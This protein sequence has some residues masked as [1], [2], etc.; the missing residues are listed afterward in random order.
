MSFAQSTPAQPLIP[1]LQPVTNL[2][3]PLGEPLVRV[4]TG[5]LLVPH[6]A[7]KLFGWFG[8]YGVEATGPFFATTLGLPASLALLAGLIEFFGG[9]M[10]AA[11]F[12]TRP[13]AALVFGMMAVATLSVHLQLGFFWTSG[14]F[15]YPVF[16]GLTA[17]SFVIRG[18]GRYSVDALIGREF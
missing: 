11:G 17:L 10:L 6:G 16:W 9:L 2:L 12:M 15:E 18:G 4:T 13:V 3:A 8:G 14:G 1:A 7:Q 5:L